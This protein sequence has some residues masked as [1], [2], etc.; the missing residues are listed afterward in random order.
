MKG[1]IAALEA[2][3]VPRSDEL[4]FVPLG[5]SGEIGMNLNLYGHDGT[6]LLVD[7][8]LGF[9]DDTTPG[10]EILF[11]DPRALRDSL[12][13]IA[14]LVI[15]H[16][17]EDHLGA[18]PYLWPDLN[19]P[20]YAAPFAATVMRRKLSETPFAS[21]V[22]VHAIPRS[23]V[24][25]V[26]PFQVQFIGVTHSIPDARILVIRTPV[27]TVVHTGDWKLDPAPVVGPV[28]DTGALAA[29]GQEPIL[30]LVADSTNAF[31]PG[32]SGSEA[33]V[34]SSLKEL[35]GRWD[36][37]IAVTCF[38]TNVSRL[39]S[40][41][42]A[43]AA[44]GRR[45]GL[46]GR[47]LWRMYEAARECGYLTDLPP[48]LAEHEV[49]AHP[50]DK[51]VMVCTG[52]QGEARSALSR[53]AGGDHPQVRLEAGDVVIYSSREIPGNE[54]PI[55]RIQNRLIRMGVEVVTADDEFVHVSGH[56]ARDE[57]QRLIRWVKPEILVP[58]HGEHRHQ[59]EHAKLGA[60]CEVPEILIPK[61][62]TVLRL[63]PG[64]ARHVATVPSGRLALDGRRVV[65]LDGGAVKGRQ[66][67]LWNGAVVVTL[68]LNGRGEVAAAPKISALGLLDETA[69]HDLMLD[70]VD[71]VREAVAALP[72]G[73]RREDAAVIQAVRVAVRRSFQASHGKKPQT[74]VHLLRL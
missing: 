61:D 47:S 45:C 4:L 73:L 74:E 49:A 7:L 36:Q 51:L 59:A 56:P 40:I 5:G 8:G 53:I 68:A 54:R 14:G 60:E 32:T 20:I 65:P 10:V 50:R 57:I 13:D 52:S 38:A 66:R 3:P 71:S 72:K 6:W 11:P 62:G 70:L 16:A 15:T 37:R 12:A 69:D 18:T 27:G 63:A 26:G 31:V 17:H 41:A 39:H 58:V 33:A 43:A 42:T 19:C 24:A 1:G 21:R 34:G 64:P 48:F 22:P 44:H 23:G 35:L 2:L 25:Q 30:A 9:G 29:L 28:S 55:G 67:V 46:V